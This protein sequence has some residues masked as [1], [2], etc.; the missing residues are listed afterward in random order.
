MKRQILSAF[1]G[2]VAA[3]AM[4]AISAAAEEK[5]TYTADTVTVMG[6]R[7]EEDLPR[8]LARTG[9]R[10]DTIGSSEIKN[11]GYLD[12]PA[13]LQSIAA[14]LYVAPRNGRFD[15]VDL[16]YQGSRTAD[17]LFLV[18][19]IRINNRLYAGTTP[20]DT[21]PASMIERI[22]IL[23]GGQAL[24]YGTQASAGVVNIVTKGFTDELDAGASLGGGTYGARHVDAYVRDSLFGGHQFVLYG[25]HDE[26]K[27]F[28]PFSSSDFRP[29]STDR[30][31]SYDVTSVG[32]KYRHDFTDRI[33]LTANYLH[34]DAEL[35]FARPTLVHTAFN[36]RDEDLLSAKVDYAATDRVQFFLKGYYHWWTSNFTELDNDLDAA[37]RPTGTLSVIDDHAF[38]GFRDYGTNA[39]AKIGLVSG[40]ESL[41]GYDYQNYTGSDAVLVIEEK[42]ER[43]HAFFGQLQ[44]TPELISNGAAAAG[45]RYNAPNFGDSAV[46]WNVNGIYRFSEA[47]YGRG[48]VGTAFRLP[49]AEELFANEPNDE[50]GNPDLKPERSAN[51]HVGVGG[52]ESVASRPVSWEVVGYWRE[53]EDLIDLDTFDEATNQDV[54][55]NVSGKVRIRGVELRAGSQ[56]TDQ[57]SAN[58]DLTY[59]RSRQSGS[60]DQLKRIPV[61]QVKSGLDYHPADRPFGASLNVINVGE[62][63]DVLGGDIGKVDYGD[64]TV[65]NLGLRVFLDPPRHHR[66]GFHANNLFDNEYSSR[67]IRGVEDVS[68]ASFVAHNLGEPRSFF[69]SYTYSLN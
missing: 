12:V 3:G 40:L 18:D 30:R 29:S 62:I 22:E 28:A 58:F 39:M 68:T 24:F 38:W 16:S 69:V 66:I 7:L 60:S 23:E 19:G 20:L 55:G 21:I 43:V 49:T 35:G 33:R 10:V 61:T 48:M 11:G 44:T 36:E 67:V 64:F 56:L 1:F 34:N 25:S 52:T 53:V 4:M 41:F 54:F 50:R 51:A 45:F 14:G 65:L 26:A 63:N 46:V 17:I 2:W 59:N 8:E 5:Q 47:L 15:Y 32:G 13:I 37:G 27:G 57:L 42:T 9:V 31:R 6:D